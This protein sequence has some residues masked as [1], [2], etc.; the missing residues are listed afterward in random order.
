MLLSLC[1]L[2]DDFGR[3]PNS[4]GSNLAHTRRCNVGRWLQPGRPRG[5]QNRCAIGHSFHSC[6][7]SCTLYA[8]YILLQYCA[9]YAI[10]C[11]EEECCTGCR[12]D[13]G[14]SDAAK[15]IAKTAGSCESRGGL[16]SCF[17]GIEREEREVDR[18]ACEATGLLRCK[19][20]L[21][22]ASNNVG[23]GTV[24]IYVGAGIKFAMT[25]GA[26]S[27]NESDGKMR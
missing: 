1:A 26:G 25:L 11:D 3:H 12:A 16:Q 6:R 9:L 20:D 27:A 23:Y 24:K 5:A 14:G 22:I 7:E 18:C 10:V 13:E 2:F 19:L 15:D 8:Q 21:V 17:Q 4:T